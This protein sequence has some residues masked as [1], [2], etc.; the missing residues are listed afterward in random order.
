[1]IKRTFRRYLDAFIMSLL[2]MCLATQ[3]S[4]RGDIES[5]KSTIEM[6][7]MIL[8]LLKLGKDV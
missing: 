3:K 2:Q 6:R 1:M 5:I 7:T 8:M 4:N